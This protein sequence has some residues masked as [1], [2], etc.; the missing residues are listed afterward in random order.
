MQILVFLHL[1]LFL[2][3]LLHLYLLPSF[4]YENKCGYYLDVKSIIHIRRLKVIWKIVILIGCFMII[5]LNENDTN[6]L[7]V[8]Q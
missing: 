2:M 3:V 8:C 5:I 7:T 1:F 6:I 4:E